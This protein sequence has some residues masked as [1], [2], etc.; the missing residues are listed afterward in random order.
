MGHPDIPLFSITITSRL[1]NSQGAILWVK[2]KSMRQ[3]AICQHKQF[4]FIR[5]K[6][7][8]ILVHIPAALILGLK[9]TFI[10]FSHSK[11]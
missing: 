7:V 4:L 3:N 11:L 8:T 9:V 5:E 10:Y 6:L 2:D 1:L